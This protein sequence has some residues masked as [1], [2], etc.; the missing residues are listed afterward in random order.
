MMTILAPILPHLAVEFYTHH[1]T[2][3]SNPAQSFRAEFEADQWLLKNT[4]VQ[5]AID[6]GS[7]L[8]ELMKLIS[9]ARDQI[10]SK[11]SGKNVRKHGGGCEFK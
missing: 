6:E 8:N 10:S 11:I 9:N 4:Q 7:E 5:K 1:P 3:K 2:L